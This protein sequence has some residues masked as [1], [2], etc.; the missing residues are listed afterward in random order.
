MPPTAG[1]LLTLVEAL[2]AD[3]VRCLF[4]LSQGKL[5][6]I[7]FSSFSSIIYIEAVTLLFPPHVRLND[8]GTMKL[9]FHGVWNVYVLHLLGLFA[10]AYVYK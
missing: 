10:C 9:V 8:Q 5:A 1:V 2:W 7:E 6:R 3:I 4:P